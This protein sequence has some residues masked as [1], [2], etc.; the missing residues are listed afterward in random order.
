MYHKNGFTFQPGL[1]S[2]QHL[3]DLDDKS[4]TIPQPRV[5]SIYG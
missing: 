2:P 5:E 4:P 1:Q 3:E